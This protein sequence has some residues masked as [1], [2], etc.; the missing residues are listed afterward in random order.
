MIWTPWMLASA[1]DGAYDATSTTAV[2]P[3]EAEPSVVTV[4]VTVSPLLS[5]SVAFGSSLAVTACEPLTVT[6]S[7]QSPTRSVD[8]PARVTST[9]EPLLCG[10]LTFAIDGSTLMYGR[11]WAGTQGSSPFAA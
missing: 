11:L 5:R 6:W 9:D 1:P 2:S 4:S 10:R 3:G 7:S 8:Q